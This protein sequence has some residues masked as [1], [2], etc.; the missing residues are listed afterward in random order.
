M[1]KT[2]LVFLGFWLITFLSLTGISY[3]QINRLYTNCQENG[4]ITLNSKVVKC[5]VVKK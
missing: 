4:T 3:L 5:E 2:V 1:N